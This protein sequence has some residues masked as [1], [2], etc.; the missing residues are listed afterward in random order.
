M[1]IRGELEHLI[2]TFMMDVSAQKA[3][4]NRKQEFRVSSFP[5]C[6]LRS[7]LFSKKGDSTYSM[8]F[9]TSIGTAV[10]ETLQKWALKSSFKDKIFCC[11][12]SPKTKRVY[13]PCF[14]RDLPKRVQKLDLVY[15]EIT[16]K[17]KGLS[18]H[19]DLVLEILPG[20]FIIIDFKTTDLTGKKLK[21]RAKWQEQYP[22]EHS[23]II[24]ISTYSTLLRKLFKINVIG[25]C[26]VYVDRGSTIQN[27][28]SY[29]KLLR[30]WNKR[31]SNKMMKHIELACDNNS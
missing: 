17:Y 28:R 14:F 4:S 13:G 2:D 6:P 1:H 29:Y 15:E 30:P 31:K 5:Y 18:G 25:W 12:K 3:P 22:A 23:S 24:Q 19:I 7:L 21:H 26:L 20:K 11:W 10:H 16:I 27:S 9:Y 8:D